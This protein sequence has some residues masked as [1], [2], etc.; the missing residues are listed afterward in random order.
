MSMPKSCDVCAKAISDTEKHYVCVKHDNFDAHEKC[1]F[2][3]PCPMFVRNHAPPSNAVY[4]AKLD[5]CSFCNIAL[6]E[7]RFVCDKTCT[8]DLGPM[9]GTCMARIHKLFPTH[10]SISVLS[11]R[12]LPAAQKATAAAPPPTPLPPSKPSSGPMAFGI[13]KNAGHTAGMPIA[14]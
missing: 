5:L 8:T 2:A 6:G 1:R 11:G 10:S 14:R 4:P 3:H 9:C 13:A 7:E 12:A